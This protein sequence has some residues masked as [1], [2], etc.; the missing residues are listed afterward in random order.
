MCLHSF[1][2]I[3]VTSFSSCLKAVEDA[4]VPVIKF[5]FDG[6]EVSN[7][8]PVTNISHKSFPCWKCFCMCVMRKYFI[9]ALS[10]CF[11]LSFFYFFLFIVLFLR[12]SFSFFSFLSHSSLFC[13]TFCSP[14]CFIFLFVPMLLIVLVLLLLILLLFYFCS[15][16]SMSFSSFTSLFYLSFCFSLFLSHF[17]ILFNV[18]I[19][20]I[21]FNKK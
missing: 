10:P 9:D 17:S 2:D 19:R 6:I 13:F 21:I 18:P 7:S 15:S 14:Y 11:F 12:N 16:Y 4:F 1:Y 20:V 3:S 8:L 5:K